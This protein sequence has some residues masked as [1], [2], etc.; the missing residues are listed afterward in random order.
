MGLSFGDFNSDGRMDLFATNFGDYGMT[1]L[2]FP[3]QRGDLTSRWFLGQP[4]GTFADP[5]IG[6]MQADPFGWG[7]SALDYDNNGTTDIAYFGAIDVGTILVQ[8]NPGVLLSNDGTAHFTRDASAFASTNYNRRSIFGEAVGDLNNDG[9]PDVVTASAMDI[10]NSVPLVPFPVSQ[11]PNAYGSPFD[12]SA[13]FVPQFS[14]TG[15]GTFAWNGYE[16][17]NGTLQVQVNSA[18]NGNGWVKVRTLGTVGLIAGGSVNRDGVGAVVEF[19]P[20]HG[21]EVMKPIVAGSSFASQDSLWA[22]FGLGKAEKGTL[23]VLWPGGV[24]N[25][26]YDVRDKESVVFPEIP[27]SYDTQALSLGQYSAEVGRALGGLVR[28]GD[29][30][31]GQAGR[32]LA[33]ALRA[34]LDAHQPAGGRAAVHPAAPALTSGH[35]PVVDIGFAPASAIRVLAAAGP[36]APPASAAPRAVAIAPSADDLIAARMRAVAEPTNSQSHRARMPSAHRWIDDVLLDG[37]FPDEDWGLAATSG[38]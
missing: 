10:P 24:R 5:G 17:P 9:F 8:D 20:D 19:T 12:S 3:Y 28:A 2:P 27:V 33:S 37:L 14:P 7:T 36:A 25:R 4:G 34:Y 21:K 26:L 38:P 23:D 6:A 18:D 31:Q 13:D 30:T 15:P 16:F 32:F 22:D 35:R 29:L 11:P 1:V